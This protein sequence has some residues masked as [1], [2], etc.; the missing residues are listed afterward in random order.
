MKAQNEKG[1]GLVDRSPSG[2]RKRLEVEAQLGRV[3]ARRNVVCS[4]EGGEEVVERVLVGQ[5]DD[6]ELGAPFV[7]VPVKQVVVSEARSNRLRDLNA[8]RVVVVV[9]GAW[10]R[11]ADEGGAVLRGRTEIGARGSN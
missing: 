11:D 7:F 3:A 8:R 1:S 4:A 9:L 6:R 2:D 10:G 5:V